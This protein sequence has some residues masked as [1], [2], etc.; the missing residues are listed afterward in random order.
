MVHVPVCASLGLYAPKTWYYTPFRAR[1]S[2]FGPV[3]PEN[4]AV[5]PWASVHLLVRANLGLYSRETW[6]YPCWASVYVP[7]WS[8]LR[9]VRLGN[10]AVRTWARVY[11]PVRIPLGLYV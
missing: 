3:R 6:L 2:P 1:S 9:P 10:P 8:T 11:V 4:L 5:H 7:D